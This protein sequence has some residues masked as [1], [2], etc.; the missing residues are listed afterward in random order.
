MSV[1]TENR[2]QKKTGRFYEVP[3][4]GLLPSV[5]T[6]LNC[7]SKPAL[8]NWAAKVERE[9]VIGVSTEL[10][11]QSPMSPKMTSAQWQM[12]LNNRLGTLK[13]SQKELTK[14]GDIGTQVH[15]LVE[16][17]IRAELMQKVG[18]SPKISDAAQW[19]FMAWEDWRKS[20]NLKPIAVEQVVWSS[21]FGYAGT[22]D[23]LAE[24]DGVL[25]VIDWK[26][27]KAVYPEAHLQNAAY[28]T[29]IREMG[30]GDPKQGIVVRLPKDVNDPQFEAV[31]A[32]QEQ[33]SFNSFLHVL[34]LWKWCEFKNK[35]YEAKKGVKS[36]EI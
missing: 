26:T 7:I 13:A 33:S 5:T 9:M 12:S 31:K 34:E 3:G 28:R 16:W 4:S 11:L 21:R 20:V 35:E 25:T 14:A 15:N 18:S 1:T 24:V 23:L 10:Y 22:L 6:I 32:D 2:V 30:H 17:S 8:M 36:T 29:A 27:G 19:A